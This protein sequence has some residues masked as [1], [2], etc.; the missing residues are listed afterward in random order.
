MALSQ[1]TL[2]IGHKPGLGL[3]VETVVG[4]LFIYTVYPHH[5]LPSVWQEGQAC[6]CLGSSFL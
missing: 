6:D 5:Q 1:D 4:S 2:D 3:S